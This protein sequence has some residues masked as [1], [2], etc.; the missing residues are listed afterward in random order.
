MTLVKSNLRTYSG[1]ITF[2]TFL[3]RFEY[4]SLDGKVA[5]DTL[6]FMRYFAQQFYAS[7]E[8]KRIRDKVII[9]DTGWDLG[10]EGYMIHGPI[11]IHHIDPITRLDVQNFTSKLTSLE[12][13]ICC[14]YDTHQA[15]HYG[16]VARLPREPIIRKPND[17]CPWKSQ[18]V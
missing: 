9:R 4:L 16:N 7:P 1:L 17:T 11:Y 15:I 3:E 10:V 6:G 12:N 5:E 2:D 13:L 14:S 18:E 8:W